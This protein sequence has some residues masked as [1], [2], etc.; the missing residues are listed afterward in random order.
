MDSTE[1]LYKE[2]YFNEYCPKCVNWKKP[3]EEDPCNE[4]LTEGGVPNSHKPTKFKEAKK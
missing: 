2:V 1:Y 4:C 3:E